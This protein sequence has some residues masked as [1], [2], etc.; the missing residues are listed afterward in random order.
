MS[1]VSDE[2]ALAAVLA[3]RPLMLKSGHG[4]GH[5]RDKL[6]FERTGRPCPRCG[7]RIRAR[8]QGDDN[9]MTYWCPECQG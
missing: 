6:V 1:E 8:G 7:T 5:A 2:E 9:R 3:V 4:G